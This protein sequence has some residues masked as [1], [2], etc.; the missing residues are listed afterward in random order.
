MF[1]DV[2]ELKLSDKVTQLLQLSE[3]NL[4]DFY[5]QKLSITISE[6]SFNLT[7]LIIEIIKNFKGLS[8]L[9]IETENLKESG[10]KILEHFSNEVGSMQNIPHDFILE[11]SENSQGFDELIASLAKENFPFVIWTK[12]KTS[13]L[14]SKYPNLK[15]GSDKDFYFAKIKVAPGI[16]Q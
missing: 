12:F 3:S 16:S 7:D 4:S 8:H 14:R 11:F 13:H 6:P 10:K 2:K 1:V 5:V 9:K 15:F